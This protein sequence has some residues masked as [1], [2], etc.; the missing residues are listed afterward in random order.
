MQNKI[1]NNEVIFFG[2]EKGINDPSLCREITYSAGV[3][4]WSSSSSVQFQSVN[5][6]DPDLHD[7]LAKLRP[8][9]TVVWCTYLQLPDFQLLLPR[10]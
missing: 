2:W 1:Q 7:W 4:C 3:Y 10:L 5:L 9:M 8:W 6:L